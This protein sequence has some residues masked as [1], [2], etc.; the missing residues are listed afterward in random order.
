M[1]SMATQDGDNQAELACRSAST[2]PQLFHLDQST[3][4]FV[5]SQINKYYPP[6]FYPPYPQLG[7][8]ND[9]VQKLVGE[10][11]AQ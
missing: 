4:F 10:G 3:I 8:R 2:G 1:A 5:G 11:V 9:L 7:G 6:H